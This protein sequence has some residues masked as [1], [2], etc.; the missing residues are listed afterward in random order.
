MTSGKGT[1]F[2]DKWNAETNQMRKKGEEVFHETLNREGKVIM[3]NPEY[4]IPKTQNMD[5]QTEF[6]TDLS[7]SD[8]AKKGFTLKQV[9][10]IRK[11]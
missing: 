6:Y 11:G 3:S 10:M 2:Y 7:T 1:S 9:D 5:I 8:L 4:K